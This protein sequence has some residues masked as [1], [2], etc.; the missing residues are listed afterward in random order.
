MRE[1]LRSVEDR[2]SDGMGVTEYYALNASVPTE[3]TS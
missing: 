1:K 2:G 3:F